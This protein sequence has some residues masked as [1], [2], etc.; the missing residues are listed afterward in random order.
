MKKY[1]IVFLIIITAAGAAAQNFSVTDA[2]SRMDR[3]IN[4]AENEFSLLDSYYLG[5]TVAAHIINRYPIYYDKPQMSSYLNLICKA[6]VINSASP[7]WFNGY[8]VTILNVSDINAF[9]TPGGHIFITKGFLDLASSEDMIAAIIAHE[10]AHIQLRHG[11]ADIMHNRF[12]QDMTQERNRIQANL[13][14]E[15][16]QQIFTMSV[17][18]IVETLFSRGYSQIQEFEADSMA[19]NLLAASGYYPG[20]LIELLRIMERSQGYQSAGLNNS[21]PLPLQRISNLDSRFPASRFTNTSFVRRARFDRI[22][23]R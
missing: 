18:E 6:I 2:L 3:G 20:S 10:I 12:I 15:T 16:Q 1:L 7:V 21:H 8:Q 9:S 4:E 13:A 5:R 14:G 19:F 23:E 17:N 11:I 22:M